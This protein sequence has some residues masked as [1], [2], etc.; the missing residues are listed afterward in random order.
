MNAERRGGELSTIT[1]PAV[2]SLPHAMAS[3]G[4]S[5]P[6]PSD[7]QG[8]KRVRPTFSL[9]VQSRVTAPSDTP[10]AKG[11]WLDWDRWCWLGTIDADCARFDLRD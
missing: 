9:S 11:D 5:H 1:F 6:N 2:L 3:E 7:D 4:A 10:L 8:P